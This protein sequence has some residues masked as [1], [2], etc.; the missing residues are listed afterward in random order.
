MLMPGDACLLL[1]QTQQWRICWHLKCETWPSV[2]EEP[3]DLTHQDAH[4]MDLKAIGLL[5]IDAVYQM[6]CT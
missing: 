2:G 1:E 6:L 4:A 3:T 5:A